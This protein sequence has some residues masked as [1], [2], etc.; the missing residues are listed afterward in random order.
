MNFKN[1]T[2]EI[3]LGNTLS[4]LEKISSRLEEFFCQQNLDDPLKNQ[5]NLIL[6]ELFTNSVNYGFQDQPDA[7]VLITLAYQPGQLEITYRDNG[8]DYNPLKKEDPDT[9][10]DI[11]ARPIGGLGVYLIK[12]L[13]DHIEYQRQDGWNILKMMKRLSLPT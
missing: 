5:V 12:T 13:T 8:L 1:A 3:V 4:G 9:H 10:A 2:I 6:E 7:Q 11:E